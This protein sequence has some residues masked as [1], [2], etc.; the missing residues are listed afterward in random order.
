M[1]STIHGPEAYLLKSKK[2]HVQALVSAAATMTEDEIR[3]LHEKPDVING[4]LGIRKLKDQA[5]SAGVA[6]Q[7]ADLMIAK[8]HPELARHT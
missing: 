8:H 2:P 3:A 5:R 4:L 1:R 7:L 6:E